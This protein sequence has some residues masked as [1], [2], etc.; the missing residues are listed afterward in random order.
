MQNKSYIQKWG[1]STPK[2]NTDSNKFHLNLGKCFSDVWVNNVFFCIPKDL[3]PPTLG[4]PLERLLLW[5]IT[6]SLSVMNFSWDP[7]DRRW[8][9]GEER[10][11]L[12]TPAAFAKPTCALTALSA[13]KSHSPF[14]TSFRAHHPLAV[15]NWIVWK[16]NQS[17]FFPGVVPSISSTWPAPERVY[18]K[19]LQIEKYLPLWPETALTLET[20]EIRARQQC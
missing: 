15:T 4:Y 13:P 16:L 17:S 3:I 9:H 18:S 19:Q 2:N 5:T 12:Q 6:G 7:W 8:S 11:V 1:G 20:S 10:A 14:P